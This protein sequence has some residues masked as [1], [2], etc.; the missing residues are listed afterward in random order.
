M[1]ASPLC[2]LSG[3]SA[4]PV[5]LAEY[6]MTEQAVFVFI[7]RSD[8]D[9]PRII[10]LGIPL[11]EIR[12]SIREWFG[13]ASGESILHTAPEEWQSRFGALVQPVLDWASEGDL[14]WISPYDILHYFPFHAVQIDGRYLIERNPFCYTPSA[15]VMS[16]CRNKRRGRRETAL[17][18]GDS[19]GDLGHAREE[20]FMVASLFGAKPLLGDRATKAGVEAGLRDAPKGIDVLHFACHG[21]FDASKPLG[22][23]IVLAADRNIRLRPEDTQTRLT[24]AEVFGMTLAA[25]LVTLS[26]C[27]SGINE[28]QPG[29]ELMGLTRAFLFAGTP[30]V[31]VSLWSV[32]DL[33]TSLL[34]R[35]FY[36]CLLEP[37]ERGRLRSKAE[38]LQEAQTYVKELTARDIVDFCDRR[39]AELEGTTEV[40]TSI[41]LRMDRAKIL[42]AAGDLAA[43]EASYE[44]AEAEM[45]LLGVRVTSPVRGAFQRELDESSHLSPDTLKPFAHPYYWAPFI[46]VGDWQ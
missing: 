16:Y 14:V 43:A 42:A 2:S 35:R 17:V 24:A 32:D 1:S 38:A 25:D 33:S 12:R 4:R 39:L 8:L 41:V 37:S 6:F 11:S 26:A 29:D 3:D 15:S 7:G 23:G 45:R 13:G 34:M 5:V 31:V 44:R 27:K 9:A 18:I 10:E 30:S 20:A 21:Y 28:L 46:L 19:L 36:E 40:E 22:S